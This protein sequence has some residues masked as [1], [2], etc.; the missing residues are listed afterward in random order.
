MSALNNLKDS[1]GDIVQ[2]IQIEN[3]S[4]L[5]RQIARRCIYG[6][7]TNPV[8]VELARLSLWIC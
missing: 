1:I 3:S 4:L 7:D 6:I 2:S 5:R 8:A